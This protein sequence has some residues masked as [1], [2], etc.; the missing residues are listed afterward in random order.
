MKT[1]FLVRHAKSSWAEPGTTDFERPLNDRG[2][3]DAVEMGKRLRL[4]EI[5][6]DKI[7]SSPAFRAE[8]TALLFAHEMGYSEDG[9]KWDKNL[10][11]ASPEMIVEVLKQVPDTVNSLAVFCHNPG[12]TELANTLSS[13]RVD[14]MPTGSVYAVKFEGES[15][16]DFEKAS[17]RF[18]FFDY[19]KSK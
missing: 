7:I 13:V 10:Y 5:H 18:L 3:R 14:N 2:K 1:L 12:I 6:L 16:K 11:L 17:P 8:K 15:W 4:K 19:P 9:I